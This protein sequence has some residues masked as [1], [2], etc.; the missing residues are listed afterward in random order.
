MIEQRRGRVPLARVLPRTVVAHER[1]AAFPNAMAVQVRGDG[2]AVSAETG[3][4]VDRR[5]G[6]VAV[7][8]RVHVRGRQLGH[9][10]PTATRR[11][12]LITVGEILAERQP[13]R[14]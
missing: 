8:Q 12:V 6:A 2:D 13:F 5:P 9:E 4:L 11:A 14:P 7:D 3:Q 10:R 1:D